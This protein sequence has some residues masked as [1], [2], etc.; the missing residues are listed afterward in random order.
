MIGLEFSADSIRAKIVSLQTLKT[1]IPEIVGEELVAQVNDYTALSKAPDGST[2]I[3]LTPEYLK[4][5]QRIGQPGI[6]NYYLSGAFKASI[7]FRGGVVGVA[8]QFVPQGEGLAKL[9]T[10]FE[11]APETGTIIE[12][13][14]L[15]YYNTM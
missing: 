13:K 11:V 5:K 6:P 3:A 10:A 9:R 12:A 2:Y 7:G 14:I 8:E 1:R 15:S 4:R